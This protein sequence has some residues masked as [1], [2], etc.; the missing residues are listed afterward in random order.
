MK[1]SVPVPIL[2][3]RP[4]SLKWEKWPC[5]IDMAVDMSGR[6]VLDLNCESGECPHCEEMG[7]LAKRRI[8]RA[9]HIA[10]RR[11]VIIQAHVGVHRCGCWRKRRSQ[12][13]PGGP[14]PRPPQEYYTD[15]VPGLRPRATYTCAVE[16]EAII[17]YCEA[18]NARRAAKGR[19]A[20]CHPGSGFTL[21]R[22]D[23]RI[24]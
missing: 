16:R 2:P 8:R 6:L 1:P 24:L 18:G 4:I 10:A 15:K 5:P 14:E 12:R 11:P 7:L 22:P 9:W 21:Y 3:L 23:Y 17:L 20:P 19:C 13:R